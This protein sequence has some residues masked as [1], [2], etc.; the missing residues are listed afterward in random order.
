MIF[1]TLY[2]SMENGELILLNGGYCR[3]HLRRDGQ[4]TIYEILSLNP[5][6]GSKILE[7]LKTK[8]GTSIFA[9]CPIDL[10][11]NKWYK[12]QGFI[13]EGEEITSSGRKLLLWRLKNEY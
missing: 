13:L 7:M 4:I 11:A 5:G 2:E 8:G 9:K 12:K 10:S 6:T 3:W 1:E